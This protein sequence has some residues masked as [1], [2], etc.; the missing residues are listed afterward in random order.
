[1]ERIRTGGFSESCERAAKLRLRRAIGRSSDSAGASPEKTSVDRFR[2]LPPKG[3][4]L[5]RPAG[6]NADGRK[7]PGD[8]GGGHGFWPGPRNQ[9]K[10]SRG[11]DLRRA[12]SELEKPGKI[13]HFAYITCLS[14]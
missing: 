2:F 12:P 4:A 11:E 14:F 5:V 3:P 7:R 8:N 9:N 13:R 6:T 10:S 1:M